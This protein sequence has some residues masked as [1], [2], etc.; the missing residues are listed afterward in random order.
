MGRTVTPRDAAEVLGV[1][2]STVINMIRDGRLAGSPGPQPA[3]PR[4]R[5]QVDGEGRLL[6]PEGRVVNPARVRPISRSVDGRPK[7]GDGERETGLEERVA[8]LERFIADRP[9]LGDRYRE[10]ALLLAATLERQREAAE[11]QT[12]AVQ[13]LNEALAEQG[14]II[15]G[16]LVPDTIDVERFSPQAD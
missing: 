13:Q 14:K 3:R 10:A 15:A 9:Q 4:W 8:A 7:G 2:P 5:V 12:K 11:L 1:H 6:T 16:L